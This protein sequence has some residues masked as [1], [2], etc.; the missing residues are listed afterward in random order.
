MEVHNWQL[1]VGEI[2]IQTMSSSSMLLIGDSKHI[3]LYGYF[4]TPPESYVVP[5]PKVELDQ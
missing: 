2:D 3:Q 5:V 1:Q 4:D